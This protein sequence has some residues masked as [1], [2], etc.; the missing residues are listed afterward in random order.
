MKKFIF[1]FITLLTFSLSMSAQ[2]KAEYHL[3]KLEH[4]YGTFSEKDG[5]QTCTFTITNV[6]EKPLVIT[7]A[8]ATCGCTVPTYSKEPIK[9]GE[10]GVITVKYNGTGKFLGNFKKTVTIR[11]NLR[12]T[13]L[14]LSIKGNMTE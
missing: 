6:S 7:Q 8:V 10:S 5:V 2:T 1:L 9:P 14:R 11:T 13:V 12:T 4:D 3:D